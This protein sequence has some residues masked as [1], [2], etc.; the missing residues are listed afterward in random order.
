[1]YITETAVVL[2]NTFLVFYCSNFYVHEDNLFHRSFFC[3]GLVVLDCDNVCA[4][5][6][7]NNNFY[8]Y[9]NWVIVHFLE[10]EVDL[11]DLPMTQIYCMIL[12][13]HSA[14]EAQGF[15]LWKNNPNYIIV[16]WLVY[17]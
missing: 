1:M 9:E 2:V 14:A 17:I 8:M 12:S 5:K 7:N 15:V 11:H 4:K 3:R 16:G 13:I 6:K 10:T